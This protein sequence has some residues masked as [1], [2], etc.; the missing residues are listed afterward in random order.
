MS[1]IKITEKK[2][3]TVVLLEMVNDAVF[4]TVDFGF[5]EHRAESIFPYSPFPIIYKHINLRGVN[6][7]IEDEAFRNALKY[8][9]SRKIIKIE[10]LSDGDPYGQ[11]LTEG[12]F[13]AEK[14][15]G[16]F[17]SRGISLDSIINAPRKIIEKAVTIAGLEFDKESSTLF[18][19][20]K[21][22]IIS[23]AKNSRPHYILDT[24]FSDKKKTWLYDEIAEE[25]SNDRNEYEGYDW[26]Q[27]Y[28]ACRDI[29]EKVAKETTIKDFLVYTKYQVSINRNYLTQ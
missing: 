23:K 15:L 18:F 5:V 14:S 21:E 20:G 27:F 25:S 10:K 17:K 7:E 13:E 3:A 16:Y 1:V 24:I 28:Q 12:L 9:K 8:L 19:Q 2:Q 22:I 29:N 26:K 4:D 11:I 6:Y